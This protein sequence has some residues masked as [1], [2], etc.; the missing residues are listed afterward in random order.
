MALENGAEIHTCDGSV[1]KTKQEARR[2]YVKDAKSLRQYWVVKQTEAQRNIK[3]ID[4]I[5]QVKGKV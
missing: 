5:V 2:Q 3:W 4:Y 1:F